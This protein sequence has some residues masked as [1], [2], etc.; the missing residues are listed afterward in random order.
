MVMSS[1]LNLNSK[2][3]SK[4]T[5]KMSDKAS[6][7]KIWPNRAHNLTHIN[8]LIDYHQFYLLG[9]IIGANVLIF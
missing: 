8:S 5:I 1:T 3:Y 2:A 4:V 7:I 9:N 6:L